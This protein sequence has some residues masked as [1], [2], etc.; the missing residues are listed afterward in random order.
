[1]SARTIFLTSLLTIAYILRGSS[2]EFDKGGVTFDFQQ[3][4]DQRMRAVH[5]TA[6]IGP[7]LIK[8]G[9]FKQPSSPKWSV[10]S[11]WYLH[12]PVFEKQFLHVAKKTPEELLKAANQAVSGEILHDDTDP[13]AI[14]RRSEELGSIYKNNAQSTYSAW[15]QTI[16][17]PPSFGGGKYRLQLKYKG[18]LPS[19]TLV[20]QYKDNSSERAWGGLD[21]G[22]IVIQKLPAPGTEWRDY[23]VALLVPA[24]TAR[25][26]LAIR[27]GGIGELKIKDVSLGK[28]PEE[29]PVTIKLA[30]MAFLDNTFCLSEQNPAL[31]AFSWRRN[32]LAEQLDLKNPVLNLILPAEITIVTVVNGPV[33]INSSDM[34]IGNKKY[35]HYELDMEKICQRLKTLKGYDD[36]GLI[37]LLLT[38]TAKSGAE[39]KSCSYWIEDG[40]VSVSNQETFSLR[41]IDQITSASKTRYFMN[42]F[43]SGGRYMRFSDPESQQLWANFIGHVGCQWLI[44]NPAKEMVALY[45]KNGVKIITPELY[46]IANGYRIGT[47]QNKPDDAKFKGINESLDSLNGT[48]PVSIYTK[49]EYWQQNIVPYLNQLKENDFDG[50]WANWEPYKFTGNG[51]FCEKCRDEFAAF[52]KIPLNTVKK[53]WPNEVLAGREYNSQWTRFRSWQ[54]SKLI[55]TL[56]EEIGR[57]TSGRTGFIPGVSWVIMA[58]SKEGDEFGEEHTTI[59]YGSDVKFVDPWGPYTFWSSLEP[60]VY[61]KGANLTSFIVG[62]RVRRFTDQNFPQGKRPRLL[63]FPHGNQLQFWLTQPEAI[64]MD[65][66][67]LFLQGYDATA[68]YQFPRGYDNRYWSA[69]AKA[70]EQIAEYE[71]FVFKGDVFS[72]LTVHPQTPFPSPVKKL[73]ERWLPDE[74]NISLLQIKAYKLDRKMLIAAGNFWEKA[75][76][77]F[78]L[79]IKGLDDHQQYVVLQADKERYFRPEHAAFW[80][81]RELAQGILLHGGALRWTFYTVE[82]FQKDHDYGKPVLKT[83]LLQAMAQCLPEINARYKFEEKLSEAE[84]TETVLTDFKGIEHGAISCSADESK[85]EL[86][87]VSG[88][89][90]LRINLLGMNIRNWL[91]N[92]HE[93]IAGYSQFG[94][95]LPAFIIP[96]LLLRAKYNVTDISK[97][98]TGISVTGEYLIPISNQQLGEL[99]VRQT[100]TVSGQCDMIKIETTLTNQGTPESGEKDIRFAFRY[101]SLP[102]CLGEDGQIIMDN[103]ERKVIFH[104]EYKR[105]LFTMENS[106]VT[107]AAKTLFKVTEPIRKISSG[108]AILKGKYN[109]EMRLQPEKDFAGFISWDEPALKSPSFEPFFYEHTIRG[110]QSQKYSMSLRIVK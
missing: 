4:S 91:H 23:P 60:Y 13:V 52:S 96:S 62:G 1:M 89:N 8:N 76:V 31:M 104:R 32:I 69:I 5:T 46:W 47:P 50:L 97:A 80:T 43:S 100:I 30:P 7:N 27:G 49:S 14:I 3:I 92:G 33:I 54:H 36:Y 45:R 26:V 95:G 77:F 55:V 65:V 48:C 44:E 88:N 12:S 90:S 38:S 11:G 35:R 29:N 108:T 37:G 73:F 53:I 103:E 17:V 2:I 28:L 58:D 70:N 20:I 105:Q 102:S 78:T 86:N 84:N 93:L 79:N 75:N 24:K 87:F 25:I 72:D 99:Q 59:D 39:F 83:D 22:D 98:D 68:V 42:G 61:S 64:A 56:N 10:D 74:N 9:D 106:S 16:S 101:H 66:L 57:V 40:G 82:P 34:G 110:G 6:T 19:V 18:N 109:I 15:V 67:S 21:T 71:E 63:G 81:G 107:D 85:N 94:L 51:C 41:V